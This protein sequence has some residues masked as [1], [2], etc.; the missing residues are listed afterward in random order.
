MRLEPS[1]EPM[2]RRMDQKERA[3]FMIPIS[4]IGASAGLFLIAARFPVAA[5]ASV[6]VGSVLG[7]VWSVMRY[8]KLKRLIMPLK[9]CFLEI[10]TSCFV[11]VQPW[12]DGQYE[13]CRVYFGEIEGLVKGAKT[14]G[15]YL[16]TLKQGQS[17]IQGGGKEPRSLFYVSPFG[18][19]KEEIQA[20]Y[21][22]IKE[23]LQETAK[24]FE[25]EA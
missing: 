17:T 25:Y 2:Y 9:G 7:M 4:G 24:V 6:I 19:R 14:G 23:R 20:L 21:Q 1:E 22:T 8:K 18:Y 16:R 10:Q 13:S 12:K 15:F 5:G 3:L 11:A